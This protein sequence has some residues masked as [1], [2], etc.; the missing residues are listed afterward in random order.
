MCNSLEYIISIKKLLFFFYF[1]KTTVEQDDISEVKK[2]KSSYP[3]KGTMFQ[4]W[5][6]KFPKTGER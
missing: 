3:A 2:M 1:R 6:N 5:G 4:M